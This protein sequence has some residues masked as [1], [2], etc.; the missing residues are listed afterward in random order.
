LLP[1]CF[2]YAA[3]YNYDRVNLGVPG[4]NISGW[5]INIARN[6]QRRVDMENQL[7]RLGLADS[8]HRFEGTD[9]RDLTLETPGPL[10]PEEVGCWL[11]HYTLIS[12]HGDPDVPLH[13]MEDDAMIH[14]EMSNVIN[15]FIEQRDPNTWDILYTDVMLPNEVGNFKYLH[16]AWQAFQGNHAVRYLDLLEVHF[17]AATSY[18]INAASVEKITVLLKDGWLGDLPYDIKLRQLIQVR[19]IRALVTFPFFTTLSQQSDCSSI[20]TED[21]SWQ[22]MDI[23]R[24]SFY[25]GADL[26]GLHQRM[27]AIVVTRKKDMHVEVYQGLVQCLVDPD[28]KMI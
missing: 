11:S 15:A 13:I 26:E 3:F 23:Y 9:G 19:Q 10:K 12:E 16:G 18:V 27:Q 17:A 4:V 6:T 7:G 8:Y 1:A 2:C 14:P 25:V 28:F 24:R 5:Y 20:K 22:A 21:W